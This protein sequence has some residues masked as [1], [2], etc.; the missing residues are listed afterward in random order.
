MKIVHFKNLN[1]IPASHED[2]KDPGALKK[3]LL[4]RDDLPAG[5]VQMINWARLP[6]SKTFTPHYHEQMMEVFIIMNGKVKAK[7][8]QDEAI[9]EK[10]DL[11]I[12]KE[13][14]IHT[15]ENLSDEDIDYLAM[16]VVT[17]EGGKTVNV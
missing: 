8:G 2:P 17:G 16:G 6:K 10:G 1:F 14:E 11:V 9:L 3:V 12:A 7:I 15:F 5:R 4:K 13:G